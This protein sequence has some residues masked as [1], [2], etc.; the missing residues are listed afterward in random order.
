MNEASTSL[1]TALATLTDLALTRIDALRRNPRLD[2]D[3]RVLAILQV[4]DDAARERAR[5]S[6][7]R[8]SI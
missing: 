6:R 8:L 5:A 3:E 1:A 4:L 7:L 2:A